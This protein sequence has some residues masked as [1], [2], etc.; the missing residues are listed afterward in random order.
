MRTLPD[1]DLRIRN[2][3]AV[4]KM[5]AA[6]LWQDFQR[7]ATAA[8][9]QYWGKAVEVSGKVTSADEPGAAKAAV[10]FAQADT[11]GV[12]ARLLDDDAAAILKVAS[13]GQRVTLK[14]FCEGLETDL[15]LK[16]C[17]LIELR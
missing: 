13:A 12:R 11:R 1:Q 17:V 2:A 9:R 5:T 7:D 16:S 3:V 15:V 14:C 6:D 4:A 8:K 10:F